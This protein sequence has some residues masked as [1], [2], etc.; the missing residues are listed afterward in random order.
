[1]G[2]TS[3]MDLKTLPY[4]RAAANWPFILCPVWNSSPFQLPRMSSM[5]TVSR[6]AQIS[7]SSAGLMSR[8]LR[9]SVNRVRALCASI[10]PPKSFGSGRR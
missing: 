7:S 1:M 3:L 9:S 8:C 4:Q 10:I 6:A 2:S 5:R